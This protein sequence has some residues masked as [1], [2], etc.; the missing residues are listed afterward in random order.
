MIVGR[1]DDAVVELPGGWETA[2][3]LDYV[4]MKES[5]RIQC[6]DSNPGEAVI[7]N[8]GHRPEIIVNSSRR[9]F[10]AK[11]SQPDRAFWV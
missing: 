7:D 8:A 5:D 2:A 6:H 4:I 1:A 11:S 9:S 3:N 10:L